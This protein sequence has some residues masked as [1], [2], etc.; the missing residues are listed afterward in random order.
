VWAPITLA[1]VG[2]TSRNFSKRRA[3]R[4]GC[5]SGHNFWRRLAPEIWEDKKRLKFGTTSDNYRLRSR[6]S[7]PPPKIWEGKKSKI[8]RDFWQLSSLIANISVMDPLVENRKSSWSTTTHPTLSEKRGWTLVH[9]QKSYR[10]SCWP[11][12]VEFR[13]DFRQLFTLI[14]QV[15]LLPAD[16]EPPKIVSAVAAPGGLTLGSAPYF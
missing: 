13:P 1:L 11:T 14:C 10:R 5:S 8:E 2:V 7:R 15:A 16:F 3:A 9:K 6:I 12:Q 4:Q